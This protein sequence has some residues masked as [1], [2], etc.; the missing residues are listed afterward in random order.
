MK[1]RIVSLLLLICTLLSA[2]PF[3]ATAAEEVLPKDETPAAPSEMA[4]AG[5]HSLTKYDALYIG[6]DGGRTENGGSLIGLYTAFGDDATVDIAGGKW[7]NKMDAT[8]AT[9]IVLRDSAKTAGVDFAKEANGNGFG[10]H[11][12][13][14]QV[15]SDRSNIGLTLPAAWADLADFTLEHG[16]ALDAIVDAKASAIASVRLGLLCGTW[17]PGKGQLDGDKYMVRWQITGEVKEIV[18]TYADAEEYTY[19]D[20]YKMIGREAGIVA[21]Y[22]KTTDDVGAVSYLITYNTGTYY[23]AAKVYSAK[24]I[25]EMQAVAKENTSFPIFS[26]FNGMSGT[27]YSLRVYDAALTE[28]EKQHNAVV[29]VLAYAGADLSAYAT[30]R[31]DMR[32]IVDGMLST[33]LFSDDKALIEKK[34]EE[35]V[36]LVGKMPDVENTLY[37]TDGLTFFASAY[38][39]LS[40]GVVDGGET[41]L[42]WSNALNP[43]ESATLTGG[44]KA[45]ANGGLTVVVDIEEVTGGETNLSATELSNKWKA[46]RDFGIYMPSSALP[47]EDYTVEFVYNPVGITV[48]GADGKME[49]FVDEV[50]ANG[51]VNHPMGFALGPLRAM[52][53]SCYRTSIGCSLEK[54]WY[55][56]PSGNYYNYRDSSDP[57]GFCIGPESS[58]YTWGELELD[59]TVSYSIALDCENGAARYD[60]Y[61]NA[62][63]IK[64]LKIPERFYR[65]PAQAGNRFELLMGL[66]GTAYSVRV[67]DRA[68]TEA[69]IAQNKVADLLYYFDLGD[70]YIAR[71]ELLA[72]Q[73]GDAAGILF[74]VLGK[75]SFLTD[76]DEVKQTIEKSLKAVWMSY[77]GYGIRK[78]AKKDGIRYY[79][80]CEAESVAAMWKNGYVVELGAIVN[81]NAN[82][83]PSIESDNYDYKIVAYDSDAGRNSP[84]FVDEDTFAVTVRYENTDKAVSMM[85]VFVRGYVKLID[86]EG[87]VTIYYIETSEEEYGPT[88]LFYIYESMKDK[89]GVRG[90]EETYAKIVSTL[91]GCYEKQWIYVDAS[92]AAGGDGSKTAPFRS[93]AAGFSRCKELLRAVGTPTRVYLVLNDGEYGVYEE[94]TLTNADMPYLFSTF[95]ITS[96][97]GNSVLTTTKSINS[98]FAQYADN[99]WVC[100]LNKDADGNYPCFRALYVDGALADLS[101]A[102]GRDT[103]SPDVHFTMFEH[104]YDGPWDRVK[105]LYDTFSLT[106]NSESGYPASRPD[107]DALFEVYKEQFLALMDMEGRYQ[108]KE[109]TID[110]VPTLKDPSERYLAAFNEQKYARLALDDMISQYDAYKGTDEAKKTAFSK[111][112]PSQFA[113]NEAYCAKF[114]ELRD[115]I[116][117]DDSVGSLKKYQPTIKTNAV[118]QA[119]HYIYEELVGDLRAEMEDG[120][121][122][123]LAAYNALKAKYDKADAAG[124]AKMQAEMDLAAAKVADETWFRYAL[125]GYGPEMH[126]GGQWWAN[127]IHVSGIDYDDFAV[128]ANGKK[129]VAV[130]LEQDE[131]VNYQRREGYSHKNRVIFMKDALCYVDSEGEYYYD[132]L[133]GKLYYYSEDDVSDKTFAH[134]TNDYMFKLTKVGGVIFSD[135]RFTGMDDDYLAHNDGCV[136]LASSGATGQ[137]YDREVQE[138][139]HSYDRSVIW[140]DSCYGLEVYNCNF[141]DLPARAIFGKHVLENIRVQSCTFENLGGGAIQLGDGNHERHWK[142]DVNHIENVTVTDNYVYNVA[143]E[144]F[145]SAAIWLHYGRNVTVTYN[146]VDRC[147]YSAISL[148]Y[149]YNAPKYNPGEKFCNLYNVEIAYNYTTN[150]MRNIGD[151]GGIYVAG[152]NALRDTE[153]YFNFI[154][155]NFVV[156]SNSTGDGLGNQLCSI[157]FDGATS[158]WECYNNVIVEQSYGAA[159]GE[160]DGFDLTD[161]ED[162]KYLT[163]LRNRYKGSFFIYLQHIEGQQTYNN[164]LRGNY[165]LN[166]RATDPEQQK[167]EVYKTYVNDAYNL[168]EQNTHYVTDINRIPASAEDIICGTGSYGHEGDPSFLW[169]NDY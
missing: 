118:K 154:H 157:Y 152:G 159:S 59:E 29:D 102:G 90:E 18:N 21:S 167:K 9:D 3:V 132:E 113:D 133:S 10:F 82:T 47:G 169:N 43:S 28:A 101:Y 6:A 20:A 74:S 131:Y 72:E 84:F 135:L 79:F 134:A 7:K 46:K 15:S 149:T 36:A 107:L 121:A 141:V 142:T 150:F 168:I 166:V 155:D 94:Q 41:S 38:K 78:D 97:G 120:R 86:P 54:R 146:T 25:A 13:A 106:A 31:P 151:G 58:D 1:K 51:T 108:R 35:V 140:L 117:T 139:N 32:A 61:S 124:K 24:E 60:I 8:G 126:L 2:F 81:V 56:H 111:F 42:S 163:A 19:R 92:V 37:V 44:Y 55:Y 64:T 95:E 62:E 48:E 104:D 119:K 73:M 145:S 27:F 122:R 53:H 77:E 115:Q 85:N 40:S 91:D 23:P 17:I 67:Y 143:W 50:S 69:E 71:I 68:L 11:L 26:L 105:K 153:G 45:N 164:L 129:H 116:V 22:S 144:Y 109:L 137:V 4:P 34:M 75:I 80:S 112:E 128:D 100:Q 156:M 125:E 65:T 138:N 114:T 99:V 148:G 161:E 87:G 12:T 110:S 162:V 39:S 160:N 127:T 57:F 52:L 98:D 5:T 88:S 123:N 49:R 83:L 16:S 130:Y 89:N 158:H 147:S 30:L 103:S 96:A 165:I 63:G 93:F 70:E 136:T 33:S 14:G 76:K 66:A